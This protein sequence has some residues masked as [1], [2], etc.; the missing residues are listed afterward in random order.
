M[1]AN[2]DDLHRNYLDQDAL[3]RSLQ[4][5]LEKSLAGFSLLH[6]LEVLESFEQL[7][8]IMLEE[9]VIGWLKY[10][11]LRKRDFEALDQESRKKLITQLLYGFEDGAHKAELFGAMNNTY[12]DYEPVQI[13][14]DGSIVWKSYSPEA[15]IDDLYGQIISQRLLRS[16]LPDL[17]DYVLEV[18]QR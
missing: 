8:P 16:G 2:T 10:L 4:R 5:K 7:E 14:A 9:T 13:K 12:L 18:L 15:I 11:R 17:A 3:S 6:P 1:T